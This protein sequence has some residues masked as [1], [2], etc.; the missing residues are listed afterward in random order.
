MRILVVHISPI[1]GDKTSPAVLVVCP[2][3]SLIDDQ[4]RKI[5]DGS[6]LSATVLKLNQG[7]SSTTAEQLIDN[8]HFSPGLVQAS[9]DLVYLHPEACLSSKHG[10]ELLHSAAYQKA[11]QAIVIDESP[12]HIGMVCKCHF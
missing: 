5:N 6:D 12:L 7:R 8:E 9:F 4:I 1:N 11:V 10:F 2:I 3:N